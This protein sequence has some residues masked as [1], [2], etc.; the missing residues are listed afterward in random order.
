MSE[1]MICNRCNKSG[2]WS[3]PNKPKGYSKC[4]LH[5]GIFCYDCHGLLCPR[6]YVWVLRDGVLF[7]ERSYLS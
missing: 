7:R 1:S 6:E 5:N 4:K 3:T 2:T